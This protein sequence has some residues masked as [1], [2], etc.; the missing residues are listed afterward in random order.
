MQSQVVTHKLYAQV[1]KNFLFKEEILV[2]N[3]WT[4]NNWRSPYFKDA[5]MDGNNPGSRFTTRMENF[6]IANDSGF[7][8]NYP[9]ICYNIQDRIKN[10]FNLH[11][12]PNP[13]SFY[14]GI[15]NGIGFSDPSPE[16]S[17]TNTTLGY[18]FENLS[19]DIDSYTVSI[20]L[21]TAPGTYIA[22]HYLSPAEPV[23]DEFTG[24]TPSTAYY[25]YITPVAD[26]FSKT[27]TYTFITEATATCPVP[28]NIVATLS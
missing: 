25:L 10:F 6:Q 2:L 11:G 7:S 21:F 17:P 13:R 3:E 9:K 22:T 16:L 23:T 4:I 20:A 15:V 24:L 8:I 14:D 1:I 27:F 19:E 12:C 18:T 26:Q 5:G 28:Q